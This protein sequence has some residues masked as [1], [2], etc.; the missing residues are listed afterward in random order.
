ML[1][2]GGGSSISIDKNEGLR[3]W[4]HE[5]LCAIIAF[6]SLPLVMSEVI[7]LYFILLVDLHFPET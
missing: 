7:Y 1:L 2:G 6:A 5:R 3:I 4:H